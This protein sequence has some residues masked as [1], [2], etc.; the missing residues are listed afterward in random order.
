MSEQ[1]S[2]GGQ[3]LR[4]FP[5]WRQGRATPGNLGR[6]GHSFRTLDSVSALQTEER[7]QLSAGANIHPRVNVVQ[8]HFVL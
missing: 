6:P 7:G 4:Q 5:L 2:L 1:G 8:C 3:G